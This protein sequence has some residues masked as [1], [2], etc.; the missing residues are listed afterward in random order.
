MIDA[1]AMRTYTDVAR[2]MQ[3][4]LLQQQR[5]IQTEALQFMGRDGLEAVVFTDRPG[6]GISQS[7]IQRS[8]H[9]GEADAAAQCTVNTYGYEYADSVNPSGNLIF[10]YGKILPRNTGKDG[11]TGKCQE[12]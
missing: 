2:S 4:L 7:D 6:S 5:D 1:Y 8:M 3:R 12:R 10:Q 11:L 9:F